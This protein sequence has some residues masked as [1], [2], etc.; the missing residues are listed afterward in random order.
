MNQTVRTGAS[1]SDYPAGPDPRHA[2]DDA[3]EIFGDTMCP[4]SVKQ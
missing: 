3:S 1:H 2:I 4:H